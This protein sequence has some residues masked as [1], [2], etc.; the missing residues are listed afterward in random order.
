M[1]PRTRFSSL[2][3]SSI[4]TLPPEA[5]D[6]YLVDAIIVSENELLAAPRIVAGPDDR[7]FIYYS[8]HGTRAAVRDPD[9][10]T[11][12]R[13]ALVPV[14]IE[15]GPEPRLLLDHEL[16]HL[17]SR[18]AGAVTCVLDCCHSAGATRA[19]RASELPGAT[20]RYLDL[21]RDLG[22]RGPLTS[23]GAPGATKPTKPPHAP[24]AAP[25]TPPA[26]GVY[27]ANC[28]AARAA[29]AAAIRRREPGYRPV[30]DRDNDGVACE[31]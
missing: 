14:D 6:P 28:D 31:S 30:L 18:I 22:W 1:S 17:L 5:I 23:S 9:G 21:Q 7:V 19:A 16:N 26:A 13:E 25:T 8:G 29:G 11:A 2:N 24:P 20:A 4:P 15:D 27:Y 3:D 10:H 12:Y